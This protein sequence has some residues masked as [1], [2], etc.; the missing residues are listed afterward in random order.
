MTRVLSIL[1]LCTTL[2]LPAGPAAAQGLPGFRLEPVATFP[3]FASS[4]VV[5]SHGVVYATT[6]DGWI[7]RFDSVGATKIASLPTHAGGN[8]GLLGMALLDDATAA[9]HYTTWSGSMILE[10]VVATVDLATGA[11][12][13]LHR[14]LCNIDFPESGVSSE[15]HGGNLTVAPDGAI[16]LG[17]GEY[18][19]Q[20][21]SQNPRWN[22][23]K[24]WRVDRDGSATQFALGMR[25]PYDLAWDPTLGRLVVSDNGPTDGDEIHIIDAGANC[26]WPAT[27][28]HQP[29]MTGAVP[30]VYAFPHTVAP[31]GLARLTGAHALLSGGYLSTAFVPRALFYFPDLTTTPVADP[32]PL[33]EGGAEYPIDVTESTSGT[34]YVVTS[35][36]TT[37]TL[38]RLVAPA[39]GDC[40]GDGT[41]DWRDVYPT[42]REVAEGEHAARS[43]QDG[44]Y[45]GSWGCDADGNGLINAADLDALRLL[46]GGRRRAVR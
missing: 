38:Q 27:W 10:D 37:S 35:G 8:A 9:V 21:I 46:V 25:N 44:E 23:G 24:V 36:A 18:G 39:R 6:T 12:T 1:L 15:H 20:S 5:D 43:A 4:V 40:N 19:G 41:T 31:T 17:I 14:F 30:P 28:G 11:S 26:G 16:F 32:F 2:L 29:P 33:I 42:L 34:I 22:G 45:R 7:H 3:G 13:P